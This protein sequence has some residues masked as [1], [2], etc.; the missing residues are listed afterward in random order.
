MAREHP[1]KQ[2][3]LPPVVNIMQIAH[4]FFT[5]PQGFNYRP[6]PGF[7]FYSHF[8]HS[9]YCVSQSAPTSFL[10]DFLLLFYN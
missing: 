4:G 8:P 3:G 6:T 7:N 5:S 10:F 1:W 9:F 2:N